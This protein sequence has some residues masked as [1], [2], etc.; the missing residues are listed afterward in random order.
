MTR[1]D[2]RT[3]LDPEGLDAFVERRGP[4]DP[5]AGTADPRS[6][7]EVID[8]WDYRA[9]AVWLWR[10]GTVWIGTTGFLCCA[11]YLLT[12]GLSGEGIKCAAGWATVLTSVLAPFFGPKRSLRLERRR[13]GLTFRYGN[14][15]GGMSW[16]EITSIVVERTWYDEM[17]EP[18]PFVAVVESDRWRVR[19]GVVHQRLVEIIEEQT[20]ALHWTRMLQAFERGDPFSFG[21]IEVTPDHLSVAGKTWPWTDIS[22]LEFRE[23]HLILIPRFMRL[24]G[25]YELRNAAI[26]FRH[27]FQQ[28]ADDRLAGGAIQRSP[29][30]RQALRENAVTSRGA[31]IPIARVIEGR[32]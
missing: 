31:S 16:T 11:W 23:R 19:L 4:A 9:W 20:L 27:V 5:R 3:G 10:A 22:T 14:V 13:D 28:L 26:P 32:D 25:G 1:I 30:R 24:T 6:L 29:V 7:G 21:A 2:N 15:S 17:H 12:H 18:Y 8:R